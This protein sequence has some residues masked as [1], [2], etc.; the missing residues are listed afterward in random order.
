MLKDVDELLSRG[1]RKSIVLRVRLLSVAL[2]TLLFVL[3]PFAHGSPVDPSSPGFWDNGDSD[4]II[5]FLTS[6]LHLID[7]GARPPVGVWEAVSQKVREHP[8]GVVPQRAYDPGPPRAPPA[9]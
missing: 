6:D 4:D 8:A 9:T 5:L 2:A 1:S 7:S 3:T